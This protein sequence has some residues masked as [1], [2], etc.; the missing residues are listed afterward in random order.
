[1]LDRA[2]SRVLN[3][4]SSLSMVLNGGSSL[5]RVLN[6]GSSLSMVL[7]GGS[8]LSR[9]L[10]GGRALSRAPTEGSCH[11]W[12]VRRPC[13]RVG[14]GAAGQH[15]GAA[16]QGPGEEG[17]GGGQQQQQQAWPA[18]RSVRELLGSSEHGA[19]VTVQGWVQSVRSQKDVVFVDVS[20][21]SCVTPVQVVT[22]PQ[23]HQRSLNAGC[24]VEVRGIWQSRGERRSG[25]VHAAHVHVVGACDSLAFPLNPRGRHPA[26]FAR[27]HPH[28]RPRTATFAALL[29]VRHAAT[30]ALHAHLQA[31]G[32]VHVHTP[33]ITS[34]DCEGAGELFRVELA[35]SPGGG[36][37]SPGE[38]GG[39]SGEAGGSPGEAR[40]SP[41]EARGSPGEAGGSPGEAGG[42][43]R[44][45][46]F[47]VPAYLTVSGQLHLEA[48]ASGL[49]RAFSLGPTFRAESSNTRHHLAEFYMLEAERAFTTRIEEL[50]QLME[51]CFKV[52]TGAILEACPD[53]VALF[54][55]VVTPGHRAKVEKMLISDFITISYTEAIATLAAHR[56]S[57]RFPVEWGCD[58]HKEHERFLVAHVG[59]GGVPLFVTAWPRDLKPFYA[60]DNQEGDGTRRTVAAVDLLTPGVGELCGGSLREERLD[61]L[62]DRLDSLGLTDTYQWYL[63]L[64]RF[65]STP[66][67]GFGMGF[68]RYLQCILGLDNIRDAI[69]F[70]RWAHSCDL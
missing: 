3:G 46:F 27:R 30:Q 18:A 9:V 21:G 7:N 63:D 29:R 67:G 54:H 66:H 13:P 40:G 68:E 34:N 6:G 1:M 56:K 43:R 65:G 22:S 25:E 24:S 26:E 23:Q 33:I 39:S 61:V 17:G 47:D 32:Y 62:Q 35:G 51:R 16:G 53:D 60:R 58:L 11:A 50:T 5:S 64:R 52:A 31:E 15:T 42:S 36:G 55:K 37:G 48:V 4:G 57:F 2:L 14:L 12:A 28:L 41:V 38:A 44:E 70:P 20:D 8:S 49:A 45:S 19:A 69:P 59:G 10:N